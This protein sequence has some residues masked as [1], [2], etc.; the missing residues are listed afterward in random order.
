MRLAIMQPYFFPYLGYFSLIAVTDRFVVFDQV[1]FIRHGWIN[2][3]RILKPCH[4]EDQYITVPLRR[5]HRDTKISDVQ[6]ANHLPWR[7][8]ILRQLRHYLPIAPYFDQVMARVEQCLNLETDSISELNQ[9]A[10]SNLCDW[11]GIPLNTIP[12]SDVPLDEV[13]IRHPG[14]WALEVATQLGATCYVNPVDGQ[15]LFDPRSFKS[16]NIQLQFVR[17]RLNQYSQTKAPFLPGLSI[18]DALMFVGPE[19]TKRLVLSYE[20]T[21]ACAEHPGERK[22]L[23]PSWLNT[24]NITPIS[25]ESNQ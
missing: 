13:K 15:S 7:E 10:L 9:N 5:H 25:L 6:I 1:Q 22:R 4:S 8:K 14:D 24:H 11:I 3:N 23:T 20:R 21:D 16:R 2:R 19:M 17:N 18:L 12:M